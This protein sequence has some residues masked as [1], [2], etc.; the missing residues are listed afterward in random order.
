MELC[1]KEDGANPIILDF[2]RQE[3]LKVMTT[4]KLDQCLLELGLGSVVMSKCE[5]N[6]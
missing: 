4:N 1:L 3:G 5:F 6:F 2:Q